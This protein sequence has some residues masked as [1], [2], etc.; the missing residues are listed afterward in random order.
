VVGRRVEQRG[1]V[2]T[3]VVEL[4]REW[5]SSPWIY[6]ALFTVTLLDAFLPVVP[7]ETA[8]ITA[9]V[10]AATGESWLAGVIAVAAAG[11]FAGDHV[12]YLLGRMSGGRLARRR[13]F[14]RDAIARH[15]ATILI[16]ARFVPGGRTATTLALGAMRFP[17][18]TFTTYDAIAAL[19]WAIYAA[20]LGYVGGSTFEDDPLRGVLVGL[21]AGLAVTILLPMAR[22]TFRYGQDLRLDR[23]GAHVVDR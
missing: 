11:A 10:F 13:R 4:L 20:L 21:A 5:A 17:K 12:S 22:R 16:G 9:G 14:P 3:D 6:A 7:S 18:R 15:G 2:L 23:R 8:V 1:G 19:C